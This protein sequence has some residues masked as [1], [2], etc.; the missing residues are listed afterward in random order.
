MSS[1]KSRAF[2][3][4]SDYNEFVFAAQEL[5]Q[6]NVLDWPSASMDIRPIG[7]MMSTLA[8][9]VNSR[10]LHFD[11]VTQRLTESSSNSTQDN[12]KSK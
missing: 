11:L 3:G 1:V 10:R 4:I 9:P 2:V 12:L 5:R 6:W 7:I 8:L